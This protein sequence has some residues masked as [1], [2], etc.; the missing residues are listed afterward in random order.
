MG[1]DIKNNF[2]LIVFSSS[3]Y[4]TESG[5]LKIAQSY[6]NNGTILQR[7]ESSPTL[8]AG[9]VDNEWHTMSLVSVIPLVKLISQFELN[10]RWRICVER[11]QDRTLRVLA[12]ITE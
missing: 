3:F 8:F 4:Y 7:N 1:G 11:N 12:C 5:T 6:V 9:K 10:I 2:R